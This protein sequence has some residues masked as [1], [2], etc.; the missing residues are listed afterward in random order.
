MARAPNQDRNDCLDRVLSPKGV[1][2]PQVESLLKSAWP[3][4]FGMFGYVGRG[5]GQEF[6]PYFLALLAFIW[7]AL[8]AVLQSPLMP[9]LVRLVREKTSGGRSPVA[10]RGDN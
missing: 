2:T 3:E 1:P 4:G 5:P 9:A 8:I 6:I 7:A 10:G